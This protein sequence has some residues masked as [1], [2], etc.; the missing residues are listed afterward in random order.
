MHDTRGEADNSTRI[1]LF[2]PNTRGMLPTRT[3][4]REQEG[5][6]ERERESMNCAVEVVE[7]CFV[8]P[9]HATPKKELWLSALDN[10][11]A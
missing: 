9:S 7:T 5:E 2:K 3:E 1:R 8:R 6:R 10:L 11:L 4:H